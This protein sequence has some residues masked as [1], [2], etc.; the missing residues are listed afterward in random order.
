VTHSTVRAASARLRGSVS[1]VEGRIGA[2]VAV[3]P[4]KL[5]QSWWRMA[6]VCFDGVPRSQSGSDRFAGSANVG[7]VVKSGNSRLTE[8]LASR[9]GAQHDGGTLPRATASMA[10]STRSPRVC[11]DDRKEAERLD[12]RAG[13]PRVSASREV[14]GFSR[15]TLENRPIR[16][17]GGERE[18]SALLSRL[19]PRF[20]FLAGAVRRRTIVRRTR[21]AAWS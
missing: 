3:Q 16:A 14:I 10:R 12:Q 21:S 18:G 13:C 17:G 1:R 19:R 15:R 2:E 5:F 9:C 7:E 6:S 20:M 11:T 4:S 8:D